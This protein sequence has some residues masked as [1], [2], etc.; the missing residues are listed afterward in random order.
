MADRINVAELDFDTIKQNLKNFLKQQNEFT[1]YD[2]EG[3]GLSVLL[4]V[5]AYNTHYHSYYLNMVANESFLDSALLRDS[6]VSHAKTLGYVPYSKKSSMATINFTVESENTTAGLLTIPKGYRFL[7][8]QIDGVVYN[9]IVLNDTTV[10]KSGTKYHFDDLN[11]YEGQ[12]TSYRFIHDEQTNP[13]QIF[14]LPD[15]NIDSQTITVSI[16]PSLGNTQISLY[17]YA[18]DVTEVDNNSEVYFLQEARSGKYEIYFGNDVLGKKLPD[19][20]VVTVTYLITAG[21]I[22]NKANAFVAG[23]SLIDNNSQSLTNF[24]VETVSV[25]NGGT[26][27]EPVDRIKYS[28]PIQYVSQNRLV[29]YKDYEVFVRRNYPNIDSISIWGGEDEVPPIYGKVFISLKPKDGFYISEAEK[30]RIINEIVDPKSVVTVRAEIRDPEFLFVLVNAYAQYDSKRTSLTP[31]S[32]KNLIRNSILT[33]KNNYLDRFSAKFILSKLQENIDSI[34]TNSIIGSETTIRVQ[35]R[36][37]PVLNRVTN[38][39]VNFN[40]PLIQGTTFNKLIS[41]EFDV[42]DSSGIRRTVTIEEVPKSF[43]GIN[44][45]EILDPGVGYTS[46][47]TVTITGDGFGATARAF[48]LNGK[49]QRIEILNPGIDYNRAVITITGG[50]GFGAQVLPVIDTRVSKLRTVYFTQTAERVVVNSNAG[51]VDYDKGIVQLNDINI[52]STNTF[53]GTVRISSG[54]QSSIIQSSRNTILTIDE[55]DTTSI[56]VTVESII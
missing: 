23:Q 7:S 51:T 11:I 42:N 8:N 21:P 20:A 29:T 39:T 48:I 15:E 24:I 1:D 36:F 19:G 46:E 28:A 13:K 49:I 4:D 45:V 18:S 27:R 9:F 44:S 31:D 56:S 34:D 6:V 53:D 54:V 43:T 12:L 3:A 25:S 33:Y 16:S 55:Q 30:D 10:T 26:E 52:L 50:G 14:T 35:K 2:F 47:P 22:A 17:E 32:L 40:V 37:V 41:T 38:Y 5:L